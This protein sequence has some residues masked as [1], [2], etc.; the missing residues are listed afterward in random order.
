MR[1]TKNNIYVYIF[2]SIFLV[3]L[4]VIVFLIIGKTNLNI[5]NREIYNHNISLNE[6]DRNL[7]GTEVISLINYVLDYNRK[8]EEKESTDF[9]NIEIKTEDEKVINVE[10]VVELGLDEFA[11][12]LG[13]QNFKPTGKEYYPNGKI[14]TMKYELLSIN[15][16][17]NEEGKLSI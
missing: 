10:K 3:L 9:V 6:F 15:S 11:T 1:N 4:V 5:R 16:I 2:L 17:N 12:Y 13:D 7:K 14:S 8:E